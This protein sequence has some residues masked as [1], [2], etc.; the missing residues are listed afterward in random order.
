MKSPW[1]EEYKNTEENIIKDERNYFTLNK[2]KKKQMML[3]FKI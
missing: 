3:Q 2:Q 1:L